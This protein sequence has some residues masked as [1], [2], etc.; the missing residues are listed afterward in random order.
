MREAIEEKADLV[1]ISGM[2][3][4]LVSLYG[5]YLRYPRGSISPPCLYFSVK[6]AVNN[7]RGH[8][9]KHD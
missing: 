8:I 2:I 4:R 5:R 3:I 9:C 7:Y 1:I 6:K